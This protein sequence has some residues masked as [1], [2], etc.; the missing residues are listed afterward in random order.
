MNTI[1][2]SIRRRLALVAVVGAIA[3]AGCGA[4]DSLAGATWEW[5]A[6]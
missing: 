6:L 3:V 1:N 4:G 2:L 5:T